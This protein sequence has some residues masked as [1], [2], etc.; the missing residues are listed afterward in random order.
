VDEWLIRRRLVVL[1]L[2]YTYASTRIAASLSTL[3][4]CGLIVVDHEHL[5]ASTAAGMLVA[6]LGTALPLLGKLAGLRLP[7]RKP[8]ARGKGPDDWADRPVMDP[9]WSPDDTTHVGKP[10]E[11]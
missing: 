10:D 8:K 7:K 4:G 11:R 9:S 6:L 3:I 1:D 5:V 2:L